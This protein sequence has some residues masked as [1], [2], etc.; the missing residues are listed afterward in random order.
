MDIFNCIHIPLSLGS[1]YP[2]GSVVSLPMGPVI[3]RV[4]CPELLSPLSVPWESY[5]SSAKFAQCACCLRVLNLFHYS[6]HLNFHIL[7][8]RLRFDANE[9]MMEDQRKG[10]IEEKARLIIFQKQLQLNYIQ[11]WLWPFEKF[12][13]ALNRKVN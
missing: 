8:S 6:L 13:I 5:V 7:K 11:V 2:L 1:T 12:D 3:D 10:W 4:G 9:S